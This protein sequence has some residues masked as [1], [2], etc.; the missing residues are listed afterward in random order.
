M[1]LIGHN[2]GVN[3]VAYSP[4]GLLLASSSS[5]G[6]V[7]VW[8]TQTGVETISPFQSDDSA[9]LCVAFAPNGQRIVVGTS[10]GPVHVWSI[11][12]GRA[13]MRPLCGHSDSV[14][15][16][17][18]SPDG[19]L[20]A[21]SSAD[22][23]IRLWDADTGEALGTIEDHTDCVR[24]VAFSPD[25]ELMASASED[26]TVRLWN[27]HSGKAVGAPLT[28]LNNSASSLAFSLDKKHLAAGSLNSG[29]A[30]IW[31]LQ[32]LEASSILIKDESTIWSLAFSFNGT[33]LLVGG[34]QNIRFCDLRNRRELPG[35]L[36]AGH[37]DMVKSVTISPD[38][39][40]IASGSA[41]C[42]VRIWIADSRPG[43]AVQPLQ[44]HNDGVASVAVSND[45]RMI[46]SG[47]KDGSVFIW[48]VSTGEALLPA[49]SGHSGPICAVAISPDSRRIA[50]V[51]EDE[52]GML[53]DTASGE[54]VT[55]L[56]GHEGEVWTVAFSSDSKWLVSGS[57]DK[58]VRVW[59][60]S[61][62]KAATI[63]PLECAQNVFAVAFS[64]DGRLIAAAGSE[65]FIQLWEAATGRMT[66]DSFAVNS[67][68]E[69]NLDI[70]DNSEESSAS[71]VEVGST[72]ILS[73]V[74]SPDGKRIASGSNDG[75]IRVWDIDSGYRSLM[76]KGHTHL[77]GSVA[78]SPDGQ[79]LVSGSIDKTVRAWNANTGEA[80]VTLFGHGDWV[81]AVVFMLDGNS[82]IS[83]GD[84]RT[85]RIW[86]V[87]FALLLSSQA[88][89]DP[90][91]R[92]SSGSLD[93]DGWLVGPSGELLL[94]VPA[95]YRGFMQLD[96]C[97]RLIG[98]HRVNL[99]APGGVYWGE[100]WTACWSSSP[101]PLV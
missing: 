5:D 94:W 17:A 41:D 77:I 2:D 28:G 89:H 101:R 61:T 50:S 46:V 87:E 39:Q 81:E 98:P 36:L 67:D 1:T 7:R 12:N 49:L 8:D 91:A 53:W 6:E 69:D 78:Y 29:E 33:T 62:G 26:E 35:T 75:I 57:E 90:F 27:P 10:D 3:S 42:S 21:S 79:S 34:Q 40:F 92:L 56:T 68:E 83:C 97:S 99:T 13:A 54:L 47:S 80:L 15:C 51:S 96:P 100:L 52:T 16:V 44:A 43:S 37:S 66:H 60:A 18:Y 85:I 70:E 24:A 74:F 55:T 9:A 88:E 20:I 93:D 25:G 58:I 38:G 63:G 30:R 95:E 14:E 4:N 86:N 84:D 31:N 76:F 23:T 71:D 48:D 32:T 82:I 45:G 19:A 65:G 73:I 59:D 64:P 11:P 22:T 72:K